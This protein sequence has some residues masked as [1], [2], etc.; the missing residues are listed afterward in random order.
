MKSRLVFFPPLGTQSEADDLIARCGWYFYP[1]VDQIREIA[2]LCPEGL[3]AN[4]SLP[5]KFD[6]DVEVGRRR[7]LAK[8]RAVSAREDGS[9]VLRQLDPRSDCLL[10][11]NTGSELLKS[12]AATQAVRKLRAKG[13]YYEVD[14][15]NTRMEGSLY[16]W[17]GLNV[18]VEQR[19]L[20]ALSRERFS[21]FRDKLRNTSKTY[22]FGTGPTLSSFC[23]THDF[24]D[25]S[26]IIANSMVKNRK[27][28]DQLRP[29]AIVAGDPIFHAGCSR[30]AGEFR[31]ALAEAMSSTGAYLIVPLRD[32]NIHASYLPA[33]MH[34]RIIG[35]PFEVKR[36]YTI[37]LSRD[38]FVSPLANILTLLLLPL[39]GTI[40]KEV[41]IVGCDGRPLNQDQYFWE[42]D[43]ASQFNA[44]MSNI[45][46][47]HPGFFAIN[48]NDYYVE[49]CENV[50]SA[51]ASL[52]KGG[53]RV[54]SLT[55][56]HIP[57]L[58]RR[59]ANTA[60]DTNTHHT[61][62]P[63]QALIAID[64]DAKDH[65]GHFL[66]YDARIAEIAR[67]KGIRFSV[68]GSTAFNLACL[69]DSI[70]TF[71][72]AF[73]VNSWTIGNRPSGA[74]RQDIARFRAEL[75]KAV[76]TLPALGTQGRTVLYM[77]CGSLEHAEII[78]EIL[79][80]RSDLSANV[81]L[82]WAYA[83]DESEPRRI[84][85]WAPFLRKAAQHP[86]MTLTLPTT[87]LQQG[88][89]Q[90]FGVHLAVAPH[91]S[92]TFADRE[93]ARLTELG[94]R[95][96]P[97]RPVV[98]FPGGMRKEKGF[99]LAVRS[100]RLL[101]EAL[102]VDCVVRGLVTPATPKDMQGELASV[103]G[104]KVAV[105][106]REFDDLQF[107][108]FL[109][110][111]DIIVC[112][113]QAPDFSRR[114]S[115]LVVDAMLL[116]RPVVA[117][118]DTWLGDFVAEAGLGAA[119]DAT[120]EGISDAVR[121]VLDDYEHY[122]SKA[123]EARKEYLARHSWERLVHTIMT[124]E[125][126]TVAGSTGSA[127]C[128]ALEYDRDDN[129]R[130]DETEVVA[131]MSRDKTGRSYVMVDVGAH[132]GTSASYFD[133]LG[134]TIHCF[135]PDPSNR[136]KLAKRLGKKD[137][138]TIDT[139]AVSD[140]PA[141]GVPFFKSDEST[142]ISGLH[143]FRDTH[144]EAS[145]VEVTTITQVAD[146]LGLD[147]IDF[148]KIDVEGFDFSVLKGV[149][150]ERLR[151][152]II[153]C[154]FEDLKTIPLGHSYKDA[155]QFLADKGYA[156]YLS[157]WHPIIRYGIAHDW[158]RLV[159]FPDVELAPDAWGNMLAFN[160]DPGVE[161]VS[162]AF[163]AVIAARN[164]AVRKSPNT[165]SVLP[166]GGGR[167]DAAAR[168][169]R[170]VLWARRSNPLVNRLGQFAMWTL[171]TG[172]RHAGTTVGAAAGFAALVIAGFFMPSPPGS[173]ALWVIAALVAIGSLVV[174][175]IGF[176]SHLV[177]R[178][179]N[180]AKSR[181]AAMERRL[182]LLESRDRDEI[183]P[184]AAIQALIAAGETSSRQ[185][186]DALDRRVSDL[187]AEFIQL[188]QSANVTAFQHFNRT[189]TEEQ[190]QILLD[191]AKSLGLEVNRERIGYLGHR[192]CL[193]ES[194][195]KGRLATAIETIV[196]RSLVSSAPK[197]TDVSILEIGT[198]FGIG[199]AAVYEA[200][201]NE[202]DNV[203][204]TVIDPLDGY[205]VA[206]RSDP[207]TGARVNETTLRQNWSH[208]PIPERDYSI[209]KHFST[210]E[211][212]IEAARARAYDV[213]IIDGDHSLEG[214]RADFETY[215][216]MVRPGGYILFDDYD[217][218]TWPDIRR[219]VDAEIAGLPEL[220]RVGAAFRTIVFQVERQIAAKEDAV[221]PRQAE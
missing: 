156:V 60:G 178:G 29:V 180:D 59:F 111:G 151:P 46:D 179:A 6:D 99:P 140:R 22:V 120:P 190:T 47:V 205:Y 121:L 124:A 128:V 93:A 127:A 118:K 129:I 132:F 67:D 98:L 84:K 220:R 38:F 213:L 114:T 77:Y 63:V 85:R 216:P 126:K 145:P 11:W 183:T 201:A 81:N 173:I 10:V 165:Q 206:G 139:R 14:P 95:P 219:Y 144:R 21:A 176:V 87:K 97:A 57:A 101:T 186:A 217:V 105:E 148:L 55:P 49:H 208:A 166:T 146:E 48:Y 78:Q 69:P 86:R 221:E 28:L 115:G 61:D 209:I 125:R 70:D 94:S 25:G 27:L 194:Q 26:C 75:L 136:E 211:A 39:A 62:T 37:D 177:E 74:S 202:H 142:G 92:T 34:E 138:V 200:A 171:R 210:A 58:A 198:L 15:Q 197:R 153:E 52:E 83:F 31:R 182:R 159:S 50:K 100:A 56:S 160:V 168:Y 91:P 13:R 17:A 170:F 123:G 8:I 73:T 40:S 102:P 44:E 130:F 212:A 35:V 7:I 196:L 162:A 110:Q 41:N 90:H 172:R 108:R 104:S 51:I 54:V 109:E 174:A 195:M 167:G 18:F 122:A 169:E 43:K 181:I 149:P 45:R 199:A 135:E 192:A 141:K 68:F 19:D 3:I 154:E 89:A 20:I 82:F 218:Q 30:Y 155:A 5:G 189:L 150:W 4:S 164:A 66:S 204:L 42:H 191:W 131:H 188:L 16:L 119:C 80:K 215:A 187:N 163:A 157:E 158:H 72:P 184:S 36:P 117:L 96:A 133:G 161:A 107:R 12:K 152:Q 207:L 137:N 193:L 65:F 64:P 24:S 112:P 71:V 103:S 134:W 2:L 175:V 113:Y 214:V 23:E 116:G 143:A 32:Y 33:S 88:F 203:H 76:N 1:Y 147:R 79:E 53:R 185:R 106:S 9:D